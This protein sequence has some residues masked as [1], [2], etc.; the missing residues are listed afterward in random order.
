MTFLAFLQIMSFLPF[1]QIM[2]F[3]AFRQIMTF[4]AFRQ[5]LTFFFTTQ[6]EKFLATL[7]GFPQQHFSKFLMDMNIDVSHNIDLIENNGNTFGNFYMCCFEVK[8]HEMAFRQVMTFL[9]FRQIM[10]DILGVS[11]GYDLV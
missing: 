2:T 6:F 5:V 8:K 7:S 11:T 10:I 1:P 4:L 9:A 3:L